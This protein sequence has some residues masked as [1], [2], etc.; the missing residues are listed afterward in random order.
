MHCFHY[1]RKL[2]YLHKICNKNLIG[3]IGELL[4]ENL[5][6]ILLHNCSFA[7]RSIALNLILKG[8]PK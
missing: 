1:E 5:I 7:E 4:L 8:A 6:Y 3:I 2:S